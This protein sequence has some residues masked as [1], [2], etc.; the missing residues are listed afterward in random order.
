MMDD[1]KHVD[2]PRVLL[3]KSRRSWPWP[4]RIDTSII[5]VDRWVRQVDGIGEPHNHAHSDRV[6]GLGHGRSPLIDDLLSR[7]LPRPAGTVGG[8]KATAGAAQA[9]AKPK[10]TTRIFGG[11]GS[12]E[13][14]GHGERER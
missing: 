10:E 13:W 14:D 4:A 8:R 9:N 12:M 3:T 2:L 11:E 5:Y 7:C 6:G 1:E